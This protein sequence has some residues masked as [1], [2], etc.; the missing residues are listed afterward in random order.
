LFDFSLAER[1]P[2]SNTGVPLAR[3]SSIVGAMPSGS[4]GLISTA[5][6]L[7]VIAFSSCV[8]WA[9]EFMKP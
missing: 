2:T 3:A 8:I 9:A 6:G 4:E 7:P 1:V 5:S